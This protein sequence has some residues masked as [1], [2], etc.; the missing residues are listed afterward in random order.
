MHC[1]KIGDQVLAATHGG[2][3]AFERVFAFT[4]MKR[5]VQGHFVNVLVQGGKVSSTLQLTL[6]HFVVAQHAAP[7]SSPVFAASSII[8]AAELRVGDAVWIISDSS[9]TYVSVAHV[10]KIT[11]SME[12]G[13]YAPQVRS[14]TI[15]VNGVVAATFTTAVQNRFIWQVAMM[16][17]QAW[18]LLQQMLF[19]LSAVVAASIDRHIGQAVPC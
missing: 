9:S 7:G 11:Y 19:S 8:S 17:L 1:L 10:V 6:K 5:Q 2:Q 12:Q 14:G 18:V 16:F 13:F 3:L 4:D 15:V